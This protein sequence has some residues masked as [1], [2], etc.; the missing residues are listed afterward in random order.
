MSLSLFFKRS[1]KGFTEISG[2]FFLR[3]KSPPEESEE[4]GLFSA[5]CRL[6]GN[7]FAGGKAFDG[8]FDVSG[9]RIGGHDLIHGKFSVNS[10]VISAAW[11]LD[12]GVAQKRNFNRHDCGN[13]TVGVIRNGNIQS[14]FFTA[15]DLSGT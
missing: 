8:N 7:G 4:A 10:G 2:Y 11:Q 6:C 9:R 15:F 13:R 3:Q 5:D 1:T 14:E 12:A